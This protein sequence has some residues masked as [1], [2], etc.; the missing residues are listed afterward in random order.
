MGIFEPMKVRN[1]ASANCETRR[2]GLRWVFDM[3]S[4]IV[5][6]V[7]GEL[8]VFCGGPIQTLN[9][10]WFELEQSALQKVPVLC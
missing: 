5:K 2:N 3:T 9:K 10:I 6:D 1:Y 4:R 8:R 7:F